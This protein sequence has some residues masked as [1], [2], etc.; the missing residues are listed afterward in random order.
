MGERGDE[1]KALEPTE[2]LRAV[3]GAGFRAVGVTL[4][5]VLSRANEAEG[6]A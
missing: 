1:S 3:E 2:F 4:P 6:V 5:G